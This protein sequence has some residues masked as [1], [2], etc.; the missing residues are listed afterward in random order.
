[1]SH[2][3]K[4]LHL[5]DDINTDDIIPANRATNDDLDS[6]KHYALEHVIGAGELLKYDVIEAGENFG[7]GSSRE[8]APIALQAA[9]IT[10]IQ[11]AIVR[12]NFLS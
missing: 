11:G 8:I 2:E 9:G 7:C 10:K 5:G 1:M 3:N 6:L 12:R 4:V